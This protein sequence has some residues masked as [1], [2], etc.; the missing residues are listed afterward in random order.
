MGQNRRAIG[1]TGVMPRSAMIER[2]PTRLTASM[3]ILL[4]YYS[5][6][7]DVVLGTSH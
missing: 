5:S 6:V 2:S 7:D 1:Q 3:A 4:R